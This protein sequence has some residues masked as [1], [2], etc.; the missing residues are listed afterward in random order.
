[1]SSNTVG[2]QAVKKQDFS[3]FI[4]KIECLYSADKQSKKAM[5]YDRGAQEPASVRRVKAPSGDGILKG[6]I[7]NTKD[8]EFYF[9]TNNEGK[10]VTLTCDREVNRCTD[11]KH[12]R[13]VIDYVDIN[14]KELKS[15]TKDISDGKF[16]LYYFDLFHRTAEYAKA[17]ARKG[18]EYGYKSGK[19]VCSRDGD[20]GIVGGLAG[21]AAGGAIGGVGGAVVGNVADIIASL[22]FIHLPRISS[23]NNDYDCHTFLQYS[24]CPHLP[25]VPFLTIYHYP[26]IEF[27]LEIG[28]K[29]IKNKYSAD[30]ASKDKRKNT[31]FSFEFSVSYAT[32]TKKLGFERVDE[33]ELDA[34]QQKGVRFYKTIN[35]IATF[36]KASANFAESLKENI[37]LI[38]GKDSILAHD[39]GA[40]GKALGKASSMPQWIS[41]S[42]TVDPSLKGTWRYSVSDDL[43]K[44]GQYIEVELGVDCKGELKIDLIKLGVILFKKTKDATTVAAAAST[45]ASGGLAGVPALVIKFLVD[46]IVKWLVEKFEE[47]VHFDLR[48]IGNVDMK[49]L[50]L[51][52]DTSKEQVFEGKGLTIEIKP[53]IKLDLGLEYK[54]SLSLGVTVKG[55]VEASA[56][57]AISLTWKLEPNVKHGCFG[58]DNNVSVNPFSVKLEYKV[59]GSFEIFGFSTETN[60]KDKKEWKAKEIKMEPTR[61]DWLKFYDVAPEEGKKAGSNGQ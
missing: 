36:L 41:G 23:G 5:L 44:L 3:C 53:E 28:C 47:G 51:K 24:E 22:H 16:T 30:S 13:Y 50:S 27:S 40:V 8:G 31:A 12:H 35:A 4:R 11:E 60:K 26:D 45:V 33:K 59:A 56:V 10:S 20:S 34:E 39:A 15:V 9:I 18:A 19:Y 17:G 14:T 7:E 57:A 61:W 55:E 25:S 6:G 32:V 42:F 43:T 46:T 1:M 29:G 21:G 37:C 52:W 48:L 54:T 38:C 49:A 58:V 2:A